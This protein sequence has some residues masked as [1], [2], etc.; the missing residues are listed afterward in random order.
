MRRF[1]LS[2]LSV[3]LASAFYTPSAKAEFAVEP[4]MVQPVN[5]VH[6]GYQGYFQKE[7]IPSNG[8]FIA[9]IQSGSVTATKLVQ[10]AIAANRLPAET[11]N[12]SD[13]IGNVQ[14]ALRDIDHD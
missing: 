14:N 12:N 13:Y 10:S 11:I 6:L 5:L 8:G 3:L 4:Y 2:G 7:G 1:I 9:G